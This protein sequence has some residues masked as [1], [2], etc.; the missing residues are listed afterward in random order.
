M[1]VIIMIAIENNTVELVEAVS[2]KTV[3]LV[4]AVGDESVRAVPI[5]A[6]VLVTLLL[7]LLWYAIVISFNF[8][9]RFS[10]SLTAKT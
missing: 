2:N 8:C 4:N 10:D 7:V 1:I 6:G 3:E 9:I 5:V